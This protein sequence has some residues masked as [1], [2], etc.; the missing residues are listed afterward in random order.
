MNDFERRL[1]ESPSIPT[2]P[3]VAQRLLELASSASSDL[4]ELA[5]VISIDA[6][7]SAHVIRLINSPLYGFA[8]EISSLHEAVLYL[9][10]NTVRSVALSFSFLSALRRDGSTERRL[11]DLW[12][13]SLM[14]ALAARRLAADAGGWERE[15]AFLSGLVAGS[16]TLLMLDLV[17]EYLQIVDTFYAGEG[18][19]LELEQAT[20]ETDH[21]R[22]AGLLLESWQFPTSI[23]QAVIH[24]GEPEL[25][26]D[27]PGLA[28]RARILQA[29]T[30]VARALTVDGF[31][32]EASDLSDRTAE[33]IGVPSELVSTALIELPDELRSTASVLEISADPQRSYEVLVNEARSR[34]S[35]I[36]IESAQQLRTLEAGHP[37]ADFDLDAPDLDSQDSSELDAETGL[38]GRTAFERLVNLYH[39]RALQLRSSIGMMLIEVESL[40]SAS[41]DGAAGGERAR[42]LLTRVAASAAALVRSTDPHA[43]VGESQVA[44]LTPGCSAA[45]LR[46]IADRVRLAIESEALPM[47]DGAARCSISIGMAAMYPHQSGVAPEGLMNA[48]SEAVRRAAQ[49][50]EQMFMFSDG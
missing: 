13:R 45:N 9:G 43:R 8:R 2:I 32:F 18:T 12:R 37:L 19:L 28:R 20:L 50:P 14:T 29:A 6:S 17:P 30:L 3:P 49:S 10:M 40:K 35:E 16:G 42:E 4:S 48:A 31:A 39:R 47:G 7:L 22:I 24:H 44:I 5:R 27:D 36:A 23:S 15:E 41:E 26:T 1:M 33:L 38:L 34:L 11:D 21:A 46:L 25:V